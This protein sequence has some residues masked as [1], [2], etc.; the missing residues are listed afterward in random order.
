MRLNYNTSRR[1]QRAEETEDEKGKI[2]KE[3]R[4]GP[5]EKSALTSAKKTSQDEDG[6]VQDLA[7]LKRIKRAAESDEKN[8]YIIAIYPSRAL[9]ALKVFLHFLS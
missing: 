6:E 8:N 1:Q 3:K 7:V 9:L 2:E 4:K 5:R